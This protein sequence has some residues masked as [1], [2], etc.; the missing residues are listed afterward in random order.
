[1]PTGSYD[2][3]TFLSQKDKLFLG[4]SLPE[5]VLSMRVALGLLIVG[6]AY[7]IWQAFGDMV[8]GDLFRWSFDRNQ[9][10]TLD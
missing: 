4:L 6:L 3:P 7:V 1:M 10:F 9:Q 8:F 5:F 2:S